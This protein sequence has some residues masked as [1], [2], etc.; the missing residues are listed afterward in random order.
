MKLGDLRE[1]H[2][3]C[4][5]KLGD[6]SRQLAFAGIALIWV[7]KTSG[8]EKQDIVPHEL[9]WPAIFLVSALSCDFLQYAYSSI[10]WG[11]YNRLKER[12]GT[13]TEE[14]FEISPY[15]NWP[16]N[17]FLYSKASSLAIGYVLL[18]KF[19]VSTR[20]A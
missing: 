5:G 3:A 1:A 11:V 20:L 7:F 12:R 6:V 9:V 2:Q 15:V 4:T 8:P 18:L 19:L 17:L 14:D 16:T 10:L 13:T